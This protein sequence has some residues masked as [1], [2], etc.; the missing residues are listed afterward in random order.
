MKIKTNIAT[1]T[2]IL[3]IIIDIDHCTDGS[4]LKI[5]LPSMGDINYTPRFE[6]QVCL[7]ICTFSKVNV[8]NEN[9]K[10]LINT[11]VSFDTETIY[12]A[13]VD[14]IDTLM[15][16]GD[17]IVGGSIL[18]EKNSKQLFQI[19]DAFVSNVSALFNAT[20]KF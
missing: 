19:I 13:T 11:I 6:Y 9:D 17:W 16:A 5:S 8:R 2:G 20:I 15:P 12:D 4:W 3:D 14:L 7:G 1:K 10:N 18:S